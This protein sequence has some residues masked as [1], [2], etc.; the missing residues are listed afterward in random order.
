MVF[1]VASPFFTWL[2]NPQFVIE[3]MAQNA[4]GR[5]KQSGARCRENGGIQAKQ[6][7]AVKGD[8]DHQH[9]VDGRRNA[10]GESYRAVPD[11]HALP[12]AVRHALFSQFLSLCHG[13]SPFFLR[14]QH[15][16]SWVL[17]KHTCISR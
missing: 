5:K 8:V 4:P 12:G 16:F 14:P 6:V 9:Y 11:G 10:A 7:C 13:D 17:H 1:M 2:I 3:I 15:P